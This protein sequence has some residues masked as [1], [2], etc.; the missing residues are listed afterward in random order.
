MSEAAG[1]NTNSP[2]AVERQLDVAAN[3]LDVD[4][5]LNFRET[6][7]IVWRA[8]TYLKYFKTRFALKCFF[9]GIALLTPLVLPWPIKI[10]IDNVVL[11]QPVDVAAFPA[12]FMPFVQFLDGRSPTEMM[13]W[14]VALGAAM[15]ILFGSFGQGGATD[16]TRVGLAQGHDAATQTENEANM[17]HS[18]FAG[19]VGFIE[20]RLQL[21]LSQALNHLLRS[22]LFE[23]IQQIP[24]PLLNDQRIGDSLYRVMYDTTAI[25]NVFYQVILSP[26]LSVFGAIVV[27]YV[28]TTTYSD[29]PEVVWLA[30]LILPLQVLAILPFP[31]LLRRRSQAS[32]AAGAAT[33]GNIEEGMSNVLAVQSLGGNARERKRFQAASR[34]SFKRHRAQV[35]IEILLGISRS[36]ANSVVGFVA[37]YVISGGVIEGRLT[38]GDYGVLFFYYTWLAGSLGYLP[39]IWAR[40][41]ES[42]P[43]IRR[44]F[45]LMDLPSELDRDGETLAAVQQGVHMQNVGF[46]YPDGRRALSDIELTANVGEVTALVGPTG[47]GKTSLGLL[48]AGLHDPSE[49]VIEFDGCDV[50]AISLISLR[51]QVSFVFQEPQLFSL[52]IIENIRYANPSATQQDVERVARSAGAHDFISAFPDG[53]ATPLGTVTSKLSVGQ[54]QRIAIARGL[55]KASSVLILDE[56]TS[57]LDPETEAYLVDAL[58][59]AARDRLVIII[60]HRL[61]TIAHADQIIFLDEGRIVERGRH[62]DL[63]NLAGGH[64]RQYVIAQ[65]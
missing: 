54:K 61:S 30:L 25:G 41:Q 42:V 58:R 45:F 52:S 63:M 57:A 50:G 27:L 19:L 60:A 5:D 51:A 18:K 55:L 24:L 4:T 21:R 2:R 16:E 1:E 28:L 29:A 7:R 10:V 64:Y 32:R 26:P 48:L 11:G 15:V 13:I 8:L 40:I 17:A 20:F 47:A 35:F 31:R 14:I 56:P 53:Y 9:V 37:F 59:D 39:F 44:V 36:A 3:P 49:G 6:C 46:V 43:G 12:Y 65:T 34:E 22:Q 62:E 23:R 33:T 38:P